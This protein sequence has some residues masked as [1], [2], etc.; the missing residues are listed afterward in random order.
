MFSWFHYVKYVHESRTKK[1]GMTQKL[2]ISWKHVAR[3][4]RREGAPL[5]LLYLACYWNGTRIIRHCTSYLSCFL[6]WT[7]AFLR[8]SV[9]RYNVIT[10]HLSND[11]SQFG[12]YYYEALNLR[13]YWLFQNVLPTDGMVE[14]RNRLHQCCIILFHFPICDGMD[15]TSKTDLL[16]NH[17][18]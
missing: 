13:F 9:K 8:V 11:N 5:S 10:R 18:H 7:V 1:Q 4:E 17:F 12:T 15:G 14:W 16:L 6:R 2:K 3:E